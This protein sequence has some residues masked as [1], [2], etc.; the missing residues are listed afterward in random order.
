MAR[1]GR[2]RRPA[3]RGCCRRRTRG[4]RCRGT[5]RPSPGRSRPG[6]GRSPPASRRTCR[7]GCGTRP[8]CPAARCCPRGRGGPARGSRHCSSVR[9]PDSS[10]WPGLAATPVVAG[11]GRDQQRAAG[12]VQAAGDRRSPWPS[13]RRSGRRRG[14]RGPRRRPPCRGRARRAPRLSSTGSSGIP[15]PHSVASYPASTNSSIICRY[16]SQARYSGTS[17]LFQLTGAVAIL[18]AAPSAGSPTAVS[19]R[20]R[21]ALTVLARADLRR[22][23][24][25]TSPRSPGR[26]CPGDTATWITVIRSA[27]AGRGERARISSSVRAYM[28]EG[29]HRLGVLLEVHRDVAAGQAVR[30]PGRGTAA[31]CR[32]AAMPTL[33]G[34][35]LDAL[36]AV[37]VEDDDRD[38]DALGDRGHDLRVEHQVG[39]VADGD[40]HLALRLGELHADAGRDLVA[41]AGV[42]VLE[43]VG[44]ASPRAATA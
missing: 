10:T 36:V 21:A 20:A 43:V 37:V 33:A 1:P 3:S 17:G 35:V 15:G 27:V 6:A 44:L 13:P 4:G 5:S 25:P 34:E 31:R 38:P 29:T 7:R 16:G 23:A 14:S 41:H 30:A 12:G 22:A 2:R 24:R 39:A 42:A 11:L 32:T 8:S 18:T 26:A 28:R 19:Y 9:P 40:H